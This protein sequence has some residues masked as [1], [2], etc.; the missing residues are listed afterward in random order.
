MSQPKTKMAVIYRE[1]GIKTQFPTRRQS[2]SIRNDP[3]TQN[4]TDC[5]KPSG[6]IVRIILINQLGRYIGYI[7]FE[8]SQKL[9]LLLLTEGALTP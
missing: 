1:S 2:S 6:L 9:N 3:R 8:G 4:E 5:V 7:V